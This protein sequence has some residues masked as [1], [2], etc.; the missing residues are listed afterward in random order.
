TGSP[1]PAS[2]ETFSNSQFRIGQIPAAASG[3]QRVEQEAGDRHRTHS[4]GYRSDRP[5]GR[6]D[7]G[8]I[9]I[10][11]DTAMS[12]RVRRRTDADVDDSGSRLYP[13]GVHHPRLPG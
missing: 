2:V 13:I 7:R 6:A 8:K 1:R 9:D 4:A 10:A 3:E 11:D 5:G 12:L